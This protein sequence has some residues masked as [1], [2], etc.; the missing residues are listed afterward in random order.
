[1]KI[2]VMMIIMMMEPAY[3]V[4]SVAG[5]W[6]LLFLEDGHDGD[7]DDNSVDQSTFSLPWARMCCA[8]A[9][10]LNS[11]HRLIIAA[12]AAANR[13]ALLQR[14]R[15]DHKI[16]NPETAFTPTRMPCHNRCTLCSDSDPPCSRARGVITKSWFQKTPL[17]HQ[18][19][20]FI[21]AAHGAA[22][23]FRRLRFIHPVQRI[24]LDGSDLPY[25]CSDYA[26]I[27]L[28]SDYAP[29]HAISNRPACAVFLNDLYNLLLILEQV[30]VE[31]QMQ[32]QDT[33]GIQILPLIL[34]LI[35]NILGSKI[36]VCK[37]F[38]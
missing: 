30:K 32:I 25:L 35:Q 5:A 36:K 3:E 37:K 28:C 9:A 23:M 1:M 31:M 27:T 7:A 10:I 16:L 20:P 26:C 13:A 34:I 29:H 12:Q 14:V 2:M 19:A 21:S 11:P 8:C 15:S 22:I 6:H 38:S 4:I 24:C 18:T 17:H 33:F